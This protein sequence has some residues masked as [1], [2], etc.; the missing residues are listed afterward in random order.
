MN[1]FSNVG[2]TELIIILLLALLVVG[3]ERLPEL[4]R[5]LG[6]ILRDV[7]RVYENLARDLGPELAELQKSTQ[8]LRESVESVRAI[9]QDVVK[10]VVQAA[11]LDETIEDLK[12][13]T[14]TFEEVGQTL[15]TAGQSAKD[16]LGAAL[17]AARTTLDPSLAKEAAATAQEPATEEKVTGESSALNTGEA[18]SSLAVSGAEGTADGDLE[19]ATIAPAEM[20]EEQAPAAEEDQVEATANE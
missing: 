12:E 3:P 2:I 19:V 4:G 14:G 16:P 8:E 11:D 15:S 18:D 6:Q 20:A 13:V 7:R 10:T 17:D 9:P 5:K 1:I